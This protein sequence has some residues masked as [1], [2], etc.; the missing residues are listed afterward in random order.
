MTDNNFLMVVYVGH[1]RVITARKPG[2]NFLPSKR[3][4]SIKKSVLKNFAK[5]TGKHLCR[6]LFFNKALLKKKLWHRCFPV[7]FTIFLRTP[8]LQNTYR[9]MLLNNVK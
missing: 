5:F 9:R 6:S 7:N 2:S 8:F 1:D 3:S 4:C